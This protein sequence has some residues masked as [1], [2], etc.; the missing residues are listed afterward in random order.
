ML[1]TIRRGLDEAAHRRKC[2]FKLGE[3][4]GAEGYSVLKG[5]RRKRR[6]PTNTQRRDRNGSICHP[7]VESNILAGDGEK[8]K[9]SI[10]VLKFPRRNNNKMQAFKTPKDNALQ[11]A[12]SK[13]KR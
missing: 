3:R 6:C 9:K 11:D 13:P 7:S 12:L 4:A 5:K 8:P 10:T 1:A 2:L